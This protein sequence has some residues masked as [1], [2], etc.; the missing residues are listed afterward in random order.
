MWTVRIKTQ[1]WPLKKYFNQCADFLETHMD[2][3]G[4]KLFPISDEKYTKYR[5]GI[6]YALKYSTAFTVLIFTKLI[7]VERD[8]VYFCSTEFHPNGPRSAEI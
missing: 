7:N 5:Q 2:I 8:Y 6:I 4:T 1:L 3:S